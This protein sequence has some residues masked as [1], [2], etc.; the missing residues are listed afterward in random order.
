MIQFQICQGRASS[1]SCFNEMA[2]IAGSPFGLLASNEMNFPKL[3][4][5]KDA[6]RFSGAV[7]A[8]HDVE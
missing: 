4:K 2:A 7:P 1:D 8:V 3:K 6:S 5:F